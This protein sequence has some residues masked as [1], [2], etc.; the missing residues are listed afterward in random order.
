MIDDQKGSFGEL[1][2]TL[3]VISAVISTFGCC[4]AIVVAIERSSRVRMCLGLLVL[5]DVHCSAETRLGFDALILAMGDVP[6]P[7]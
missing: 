7:L 2:H 1:A 4:S 6:F 5:G 3:A